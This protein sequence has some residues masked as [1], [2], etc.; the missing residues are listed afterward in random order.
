MSEDAATYRRVPLEVFNEGKLDLIDEFLSEDFVEHGEL[1]PGVPP[2]RD[3][4]R[5]FV[6]A[7]KA[8]FPDFH[9]EILQ[10]HQDGDMHIGYIRASGTM[11]GDFM[12]MPPSGKSASWDEVHIGRMA[13]GKVVEH[14]EVV[15]R[16]GMLQ[17]LG[18]MPSPPG[19]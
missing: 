1:P 8:A 2:G 5:V 16:L 14:W 18:F 6:V 13:G 12:G 17:Q 11:T 19:S 4:L 3:G 10:Q 9:Y 7:L 15:D